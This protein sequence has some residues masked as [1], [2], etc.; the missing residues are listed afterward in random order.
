MEVLCEYFE[1]SDCSVVWQPTSNDDAG[2]LFK[3][4]NSDRVNVNN[5]SRQRS[6]MLRRCRFVFVVNSRI[7]QTIF[8]AACFQLFLPV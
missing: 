1:E 4:F 7:A 2:V 3:Q 8:T 5:T 6:L